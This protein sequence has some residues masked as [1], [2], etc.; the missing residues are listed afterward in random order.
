[1]R[2]YLRAALTKDPQP[3]LRTGAASPCSGP[4]GRMIVV[5]MWVARMTAEHNDINDNDDDADLHDGKLDEM[6]MRMM[7]L[8]LIAMLMSMADGICADGVDP[9]AV[10]CWRWRQC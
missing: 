4:A 6:M 1:M 9:I 3:L 7:M 10:F 2:A 8:Q 5:H